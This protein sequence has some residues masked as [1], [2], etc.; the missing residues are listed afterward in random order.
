VESG[1]LFDK[2]VFVFPLLYTGGGHGAVFEH[3]SVA[4]SLFVLT[5]PLSGAR[6]EGH[7]VCLPDILFRFYLPV[8]AWSILKPLVARLRGRI[9]LVMLQVDGNSP[10]E[11][12]IHLNQESR[13]VIE[14]VVRSR[15][16]LQVLRFRGQLKKYLSGTPFFVLPIPPI[17]LKASSHYVARI[18][19]LPAL[20]RLS[21]I[22]PR[23]HMVD[24]FAFPDFPGPQGPTFTIMANAS[25]IV[26][27]SL[28]G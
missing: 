3:V 17:E 25:R 1:S 20:G 6:A 23:I 9:L 19:S 12:A 26:S 18:N 7:V 16:R 13:S 15:S 14:Q 28:D 2:G 5:D 27:E 10:N 8:Q 4:G 11:Y 22:M 21:E 24:A